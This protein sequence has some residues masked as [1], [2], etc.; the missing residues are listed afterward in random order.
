MAK[1]ALTLLTQQQLIRV[2]RKN[3]KGNVS[4]QGDL[5]FTT[6]ML[7]ELGITLET[8]V[9]FA[10]S[11]GKKM[12]D[13]YLILPR[14]QGKELVHFEVY[15]RAYR[16]HIPG[17]VERFFPHYYLHPCHFELQPMLEEEEATFKVS[18]SPG[19]IHF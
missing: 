1:L 19:A 9:Q 15:K 13:L 8:P 17:V 12:E 18:F 10:S 6:G 11:T 16:L 2:K 5:I 14:D 3:V 4:K 7:E